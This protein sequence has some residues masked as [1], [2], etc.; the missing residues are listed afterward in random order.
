ML[1]NFECWLLWS[2]RIREIQGSDLATTQPCNSFTLCILLL[3]DISG[4][5][6][7]GGFMSL[8]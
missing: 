2:F 5:A 4:D 3:A 1:L 6:Q 8:C 7:C